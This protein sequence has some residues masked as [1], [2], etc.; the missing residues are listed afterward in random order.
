MLYEVI[1]ILKVLSGIDVDIPLIADVN[2]DGV[3]G[4]EEVI[5][6][7]RNVSSSI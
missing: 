2:G 6:I 5:Y 3:V 7:L 1:T 4:L